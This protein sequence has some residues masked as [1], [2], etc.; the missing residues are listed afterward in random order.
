MTMGV[1][2]L[3][4]GTTR[5]MRLGGFPSA[6]E[7]LDDGGLQKAGSRMIGRHDRIQASPA[8]AAQQTA[9]ALGIA[10]IPDER[11]RDRDA[12][13]WAGM[14]LEAIYARAPDALGAWMVQPEAATAGGET[15]ATVRNRMAEWLA[16][17]ATQGGSVLAVTHPMTI[18]AALSA[19]LDLPLSG[20]LRID[21]APLSI[22]TLSWNR[23]WRLQG[24][25]LD[26]P[27]RA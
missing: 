8:A 17:Q 15:L 5:S 14:S 9:D 20:V 13:E 1:T 27:A 3:C 7:P 6:T 12:G 4:H 21:I 25:G 26:M 16:D 11:L 22:T 23:V 24:L 10:A 18:R 2:L 19:S